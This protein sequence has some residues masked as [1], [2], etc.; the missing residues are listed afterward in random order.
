MRCVAPCCVA[1]LCVALRCVALAWVGF[2]WVELL[3]AAALLC[4]EWRFR[5]VA[6]LLQTRQARERERERHTETAEFAT[7]QLCSSAAASSQQPAVDSGNERRVGQSRAQFSSQHRTQPCLVCPV[8]CRLVCLLTANRQVHKKLE[9]SD[10]GKPPRPEASPTASGGRCGSQSWNFRGVM[11]KTNSLLFPP[12][13]A[14]NAS[15]LSPPLLLLPPPLLC[16]G[17]SVSTCAGKDP[18]PCPRR[19]LVRSLAPLPA[20]PEVPGS[21]LVSAWHAWSV[22]ATWKSWS[23]PAKT[24]SLWNRL[25]PAS[26][27]PNCHISLEA[28]GHLQACILLFLFLLPAPSPN[29]VC[30]WHPLRRPFPHT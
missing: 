10:S 18:S 21:S 29:L 13:K 23:V 3:R 5:G 25:A 12:E 4:V 7:L 6:L 19:A 27:A 16:G 26:S 24:A 30:S 14:K 2:W 17:C 28:S 9:M 20:V 11:W 8:S 15:F 1:L 22:R